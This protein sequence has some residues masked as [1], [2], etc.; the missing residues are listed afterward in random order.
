MSG[1]SAKKHRRAIRKDTKKGIIE[2]AAGIKADMNSRPFH[3]RMY[4]AVKLLLGRI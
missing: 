2:F 1:R 3:K 4:L